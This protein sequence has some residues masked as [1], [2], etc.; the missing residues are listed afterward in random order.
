MA[1]KVKKP[2]STGEVAKYCRVS[3]VTVFN[4]IKA[5]KIKYHTTAGGQ[6]RVER[7]D[8]VEF[9]NQYGMPVPKNLSRGDKYRILAV[10]DDPEI[11]EFIK[12]ALKGIQDEVDIDTA[13]DGY[14][15]CMKIGGEKPD[16]VIL[17]LMMPKIDGLQ[18]CRRLRENEETKSMEVI[19]LTGHPG[20]AQK[21]AL[22]EL[23]IRQILVKPVSSEDLQK[24][25]GKILKIG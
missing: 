1:V 23:G 13:E 21:E 25:V 16:L 5:G 24:A 8:L 11:L 2:L 3:A 7:R 6:Y 12:E 15:A 19:I 18:V 9:L 4:W 14:I 22:R 17:D 20:K 10:D